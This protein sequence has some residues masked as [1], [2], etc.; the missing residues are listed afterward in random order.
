MNRHIL[1]FHHFF[2]F[3]QKE[4]MR[5]IHRILCLIS[6]IISVSN[7]VLGQNDTSPTSS[8][9]GY[10]LILDSINDCSTIAIQDIQQS[11]AKLYIIGGIAPVIYH[12]QAQF[13]ERFGINYFDSGCD[14]TFEECMTQ[15]NLFV[16][17]FLD[18]KYGNSWRG[19]VRKDVLGFKLWRRSNLFSSNSGQWQAIAYKK[20]ETNNIYLFNALEDF[21]KNKAYLYLQGGLSPIHYESQKRFEKRHKILYY[22]FGCIG[23]GNMDDIAKYNQAVFELLNFKYGIKWQKSVRIDAIGFEEWKKKQGQ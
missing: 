5:S 14:A 6:L 17:D 3:S 13:E 22:D 15:Y 19:Q 20:D 23:P 21:K 9:I 1:S 10:W 12:D 4:R 18:K 7:L 2:E 16:F 8:S 11:K